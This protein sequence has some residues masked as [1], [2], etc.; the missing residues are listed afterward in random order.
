MK[1]K[2]HELLSFLSFFLSFFFFNRE[3]TL[4]THLKFGK[5][6]EKKV[7]AQAI[8]EK[9]REGKEN[10]GQ[11]WPSNQ[12]VLSSPGGFGWG[13]WRTI[14]SGEGWNWALENLNV[15]WSILFWKLFHGKGMQ[16][17]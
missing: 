10:A 7:R 2:P 13:S 1:I 11:K 3:G 6:L 9:K 14:G 4:R 12:S 15:P 8:E 17:A 16:V 5:C